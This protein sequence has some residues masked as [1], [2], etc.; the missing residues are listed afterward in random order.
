MHGQAWPTKLFSVVHSSLHETS[1]LHLP[2]PAQTSWCCMVT[3]QSYKTC[4]GSMLS[5]YSF[6]YGI[7]GIT[8]LFARYVLE[9][10]GPDALVLV[11]E[12]GK[13]TEARV[14]TALAA[15]LLEHLARTNTRGIFATCAPCSAKFAS[16]RCPKASHIQQDA[17]GLALCIFM[18]ITTQ[19]FSM[20]MLHEVLVCLVLSMHCLAYD[21]HM[22]QSK[23]Q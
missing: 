18:C 6:M 7:S 11:D 16:G 14:G 3:T 8:S 17:T 5:N 9:G 20:V 4:L 23:H 22:H 19:V 10:A 2:C 12:L 1:S 13:G 21:T 15:A